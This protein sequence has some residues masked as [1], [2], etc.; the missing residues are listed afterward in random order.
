MLKTVW[1]F[2]SESAALSRGKKAIYW[3]WNVLLVLFS[4]V[5]LGSLSL[6]YAI[7]S[8]GLVLWKSYFT[9]PLI[10]LLN[11]LPVVLLVFLIYFLFGKAWVAFLI[12]SVLVLSFTFADYYLLKFRDDPL[13][14]ADLQYL[15]EANRITALQGYNLT[16]DV[17][18]WFGI[19][20]VLFGTL[21]LALFVR[22]RL[23]LRPRLLAALGAA[24]LCVPLHAAC[25]DTDLYQLRTVNND[26]INQWAATQVYQSRGFL[27]PFLHSITSDTLKKP[28]GYSAAQ[29]EELL[30]RYTD[31]A[32]P[33][34]KKVNL[35]I[36]QLEAFADLSTMGIPGVDFD[37]A[38]GTYHDILSESYSGRMVVNIFAG[39]TV[40]TE[41]G[42]LTGF[43]QLKDFRS[44]TNS[45]AW[46]LTSQGYTVDGSHPSYE[47]FY[48]RRNVN[49]Y[50]GFP[51]YYYYENHYNDLADGA[52]AED[53]VL[54][55]EIFR[56]FQQDS[57]KGA[58]VFSF[59][60]TYQ[61]HG[62]YDT[63]MVLRDAHFVTGNYS[64][65]TANIVDNYLG[66]VQDTAEQMRAL[67]DNFAGVDE[68]VVVV[69]YGDHKPWLGDANSAYKELG[70]DL[71]TAEEKGL[72]DK[73]STQYVIW[74]NDAAK[75]VTGND[76][77]GQGPDLSPNYLM[78]EIFDLCGLKG[79]AYMQATEDLRRT[80]PVVTT[81]GRYSDQGTIV[82]TANLSEEGQAALD[83]FRALEY[84]WETNYDK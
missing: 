56:L 46:Y 49:A 34:E 30:S 40:N 9:H 42:V 64:K 83:S 36:V 71:D 66:S 84:Y 50:L 67:L 26:Y 1:L 45:Y 23:R 65:A 32:I 18:M 17:R 58:P 55:P 2:Q 33:D 14:F 16:P 5:G 24:V 28:G 22:A 7:G 3:S 63:E 73:Y 82:P 20:C 79:S 19:F 11:L 68:P 21:F 53:S 44:N 57:A 61:G 47:W 54:L 31:E 78:N 59:N 77:T 69:F 62:P 35:V 80:L 60:V 51:E 37:S 29:A 38:Y 81:I 12:S 76:F 10:A 27:Y 70:V 15:R 8:F 4:A 75:Q 39:G 74:A 6:L 72:F 13:K 41:R 43:S 48:N 52:I 25:A